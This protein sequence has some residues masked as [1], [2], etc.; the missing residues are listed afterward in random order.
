MFLFFRFGSSRASLFYFHGFSFF[1]RVSN[2]LGLVVEDC[3]GYLC[4]IRELNRFRTV[5]RAGDGTN[6]TRHVSVR[7]LVKGGNGYGRPIVV[8]VTNFEVR[9]IV[10]RD[11]VLF[12][13]S[14]VGS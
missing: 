7:E 10:V 5:L 14:L 12:G 13:T 1:L 4:V 6:H 2:V 3:R 11:T 9:R 8:E